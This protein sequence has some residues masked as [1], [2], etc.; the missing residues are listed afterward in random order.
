[1]AGALAAGLLL[2]VCEQVGGYLVDPGLTLAINYAILILRPSDQ[3]D[4]VVRSWLK[5]VDSADG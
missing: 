3:A 4:R 5:S 1:M 2:G